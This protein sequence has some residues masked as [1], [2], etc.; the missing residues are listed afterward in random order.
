MNIYDIAEAAGVSIATVSRVLSGSDKVSAQTR[1]RVQAIIEQKGFVP[2]P[3]ARGLGLG[4]LELIGLLCTDVSDIFYATAV[5]NLEKRLRQYGLGTLLC[6]TG[7]SLPDI[8]EGVG[9]LLGKKVDAI[10]LIGS[11]LAVGKD[12][13]HFLDAAKHCPLF[14]I[15]L[16]IDTPGF[17][18]VVAEQKGAM[19]DSV[20]LLQ[21]AGCRKI[22]Y[23]YDGD[24]PSNQQKLEGYRKALLELD[25]ALIVKVSKKDPDVALEA[26][27]KLFETHEADAILA[28]EDVLAVGAYKAMAA[29]GRSVPTIGFNNSILARCATPSLSSVDNMLDSLC[30][31]V[32]TQLVDVLGGKEVPRKISLACRLVERDTFQIGGE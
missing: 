7:G 20:M 30:T 10:I 29:R 2:N 27:N 21:N 23:F 17:Y 9:L 15:N 11:A 25:E 6:C 1:E 12:Q 16:Y 4:S 19:Y 32:V 18:G 13:S 3:F 24:T 8:K 28:S 26:A 31:L 5:S 22:A 14:G